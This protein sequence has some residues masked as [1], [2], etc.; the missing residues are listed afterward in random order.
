MEMNTNEFLNSEFGQSL[1]ECLS[2]YDEAILD[3]DYYYQDIYYRQL[4]VYIS[5][6]KFMYGIEYR[7]IRSP[8]Y[9]GLI[10][11]NSEDFLIKVN[12]RRWK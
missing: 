10:Q 9:Y 7:Y 8:E 3:S 1:I 2:S 5:A 11:E 12:I 6:L 4:E